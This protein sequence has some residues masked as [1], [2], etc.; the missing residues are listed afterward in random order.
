MLTEF[1]APPARVW[2]AHK[3]KPTHLASRKNMPGIDYA[4]RDHRDT[5]LICG[6]EIPPGPDFCG[7]ACEKLYELAHRKSTPSEPASIA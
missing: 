3:Q 2:Q 5:C 6:V 1:T 4:P 7:E